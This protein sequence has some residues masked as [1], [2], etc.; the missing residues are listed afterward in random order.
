M[1]TVK[2]EAL[3]AH[4]TA[5]WQI[6]A[7]YNRERGLHHGLPLPPGFDFFASR[8]EYDIWEMSMWLGADLGTN[9]VCGESFAKCCCVGR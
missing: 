9:C 7:E 6:L 3:Q 8:S 4:L 2:K 1:D 5:A